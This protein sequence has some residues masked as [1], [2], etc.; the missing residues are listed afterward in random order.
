M[1]FTFRV[2]SFKKMDNPYDSKSSRTKYLCYVNVKD[3]P[4]EFE[5]WM[6]TNPREQKL[7]T[8][9]AKSIE[10]SLLN[11]KQDFHE[12][13]RGIVLSAEKVKYD[14]ASK[15]VTITFTDEII[16]GNIDGGHTLKIILAIKQI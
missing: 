2:T 5:N 1:E 15:E 12:L 13:N 6:L 9:V 3:I 8:N 10:E 7:T 11:N 14:N 16:H 4:K